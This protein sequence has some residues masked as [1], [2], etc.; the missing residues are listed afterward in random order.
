MLRT[1][2]AVTATVLAATCALT[3]CGPVQMGAAAI[4]GSQ[5]ISSATLASQVTAVENTVKSGHGKVALQ[6][7][8]SELPQQVLGWLVR[9]QIREQLAGREHVTVT[10]AQAQQAL[11]QIEAQSHQSGTTSVPLKLLAAANG[12][13]PGMLDELGRYEAIQ[14]AILR[15][16]DGGKLPTSPTALNALGVVF[17]R[18]QCLESRNLAI[19]INP[20]FGRLD[21]SQ[22]AVIAA[23]PT[24]SA[25]VSPSP[26]PTPAPQLTPA[27]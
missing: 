1:A 22:I 23:P 11:G 17:N 13:P 3:A 18:A 8:A 15:R 27:C 10:P 16:L 26:S 9:F 21:Y 5:R 25:P 12:L 6:F 24:L 20:Q 2:V 14:S 7:P 4:V 19:R